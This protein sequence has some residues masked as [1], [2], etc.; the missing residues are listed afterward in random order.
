MHV[1]WFKDSITGHLKQVDALL[2]QLQKEVQFSLS[3]IDCEKKKS[4][5]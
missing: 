4:G 1:F 5:Y 3:S 2:I